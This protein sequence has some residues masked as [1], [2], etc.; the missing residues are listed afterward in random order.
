MVGIVDDDELTREGA[1]GVTHSGGDC[2]QNVR[3]C[4]LSPGLRETAQN[5]CL[6]AD[7]CMPGI[8]R[9]GALRNSQFGSIRDI[10]FTLAIGGGGNESVDRWKLI[11]AGD[12]TL[13]RGG[14]LNGINQ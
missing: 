11:S 3:V 14:N 7:V 2:P 12:C 10:H 9:H 13:Q 1:T 4:E 8:S 6:I 5:V